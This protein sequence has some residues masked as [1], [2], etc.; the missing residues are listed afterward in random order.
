MP[1]KSRIIIH[2]DTGQDHF[3][4]VRGESEPLNWE[5]GRKARRIDNHSWIFEVDLSVEVS[6]FKVLIDDQT[7]SVGPN[8]WIQKGQTKD[9]YPFFH[10]RNGRIVH[11][12]RFDTP[13]AIYLPPSYDENALKRYP[14]L[15]IHDGQ[16][17]FDPHTA[18]GGRMWGIHDIIDQRSSAGIMDEVIVV[19][20][21]NRGSARLHDYT[22]SHDPDFHGV[23]VG[24]GADAYAHLLIDQIKPYIDSAYRTHPENR[25]TGLLGSSLGG[26]VSL[27]MARQRPEIFG[28]VASMSSS[29]WWNDR[30]LMRSIIR[31]RRHVPIRVYIDAGAKDNWRET[32]AMYEVLLSCGYKPGRDLFYYIA[33]DHEHSEPYWGARAHLPLQFLYPP[34]SWTGMA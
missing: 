20:I 28:K 13:V 10:Q 17:L 21:Y 19:G 33:P 14:V 1:G 25:H 6:E 9:I 8:Y 22:P 23:G 29:F 2:Y 12:E 3:V 27:Y 30:N 4:T 11:T 31:E 5:K 15:Y 26:L 16:N 24:G 18:F 32:H 7:W 34:R